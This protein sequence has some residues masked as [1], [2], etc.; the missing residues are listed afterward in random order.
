LIE[1]G[2]SGGSSIERHGE[3]DGLEFLV[4]VSEFEQGVT[5][6]HASIA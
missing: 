1:E 3:E 5:R 2:V 4:A 6:F